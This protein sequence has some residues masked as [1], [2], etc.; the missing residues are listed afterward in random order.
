MTSPIFSLAV[1]VAIVSAALTD[2][3]PSFT[4]WISPSSEPSVCAVMSKLWKA[5][6]EQGHRVIK[7][8]VCTVN[9]QVCSVA[10]KLVTGA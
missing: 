10:L 4:Q 3:Y 9:S 2:T 8:V 5:Q 6:T 7:G 1:S